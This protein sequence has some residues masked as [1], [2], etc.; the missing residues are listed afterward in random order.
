M[1][2]P[3]RRGRSITACA[4]GLGAAIGLAACGG[5]GSGGGGKSQELVVWSAQSATTDPIVQRSIDAFNA[6]SGVKA[7][8]RSQPEGQIDQKVQIALGRTGGPDI[9]RT[10]GGERYRALSAKSLDLTPYIAKRP[11]YQRRFFSTVFS[12]VTFD[13]HVYCVPYT[14][15]QPVLFFYNKD[16][17]A[18]HG[19]TPPKTWPELLDAIR[20]LRA[21]HIAPIALG[22]AG[23]DNWVLLMY[24]EY[25][26]ERLG[27][28]DV[29]DAI[30]ARRP[31]AWSDPAVLEA[32][33]IIRALVGSGAFEDGFASVGSDNGQANALMYTGK[34]AMQLN[35]S[36]LYEAVQGDNPK[37][38]EQG[39]LGWFPFPSIPGGKGDPANVAGNLSDYLCAD[40][41]TEHPDA[42]ATFLLD[43]VMNAR[44]AKAIIGLGNLPPVDGERATVASGTAGDW[45]GFLYGMTKNAPNYQ[46][47][48]DWALPADISADMLTNLTKLFIGDMTPEDFSAAM[49]AVAR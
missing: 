30:I 20:T 26:V 39:R 28:P 15:I 17:F 21:A 24:E 18:Q 6:K 42:A 32:N 34:A 11:G 7:V 29:V 25:L 2:R 47:S 19:L 14:G 31:G 13:G 41:G 45:L 23:T 5:L 43:Y 22:P 48:W 9:F 44:Y 35:G 33:R 10:L 4:I 36:W 38:I 49:D 27:G 37:F 16:L 46:L 3:G 40:R 1:H 8:L 12:P